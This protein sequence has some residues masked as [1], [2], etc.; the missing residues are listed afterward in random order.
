MFVTVHL[1]LRRIMQWA[2]SYEESVTY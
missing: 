1:T 2:K